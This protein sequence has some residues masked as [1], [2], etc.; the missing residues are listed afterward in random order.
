MRPLNRAVARAT[1]GAGLRR[2]RDVSAPGFPAP[3]RAAAGG[4]QLQETSV[5]H[6]KYLLALWQQ[7]ARDGM[8]PRPRKRKRSS[9]PLF[10][11]ALER[12]EVPSTFYVAPTGNDTSV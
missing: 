7:R 3:A 1:T 9:F 6:G 10:V 12:R 4:H 11:E 5:F 2:P 8:A